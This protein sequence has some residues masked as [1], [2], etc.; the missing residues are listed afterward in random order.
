MIEQTPSGLN[1][2]LSDIPLEIMKQGS[3]I[4]FDPQGR[5]LYEVDGQCVSYDVE[6]DSY[7]KDLFTDKL[8]SHDVK[9]APLEA[10]MM[11]NRSSVV[12]LHQEMHFH[13]LGAVRIITEK[14]FSDKFNSPESVAKAREQALAEVNEHVLNVFAQAVNAAYDPSTQTIDTAFLNKVLDKARK[15]IS[16]KAMQAVVNGLAS[17]CNVTLNEEELASVNL[18]HIAEETTATTN[19]IIHTDV[20]NGLLTVIEGTD[21][22]AHN[23]QATISRDKKSIAT[24]QMKTYKLSESG[25][26]KESN[27]RLQIRTPSPVQKNTKKASFFNRLVG[28]TKTT[29]AFVDDV[30]AKFEEVNRFYNLNDS[31]KDP[32][33]GFPKAIIYA[34]YTAI[35]DTLDNL[36]GK[37]QQTE[38]AK[39]I[40]QGMHQYN[41]ESKLGVL[42]KRPM[43]FV[44]NISVN[45]YGERLSNNSRSGLVRESTLLAEMAML[46]T[47]SHVIENHKGSNDRAKSVFNE[48][49][50]FLQSNPRGEYFCDSKEGR[51]ALAEIKEIKRELIRMGFKEDF[52]PFDQEDIAQKAV[53]NMMAHDAHHKHRYAKTIQALTVFS[54]DTMGGCKSGNERAQAINGRVAILDALKGDNLSP[55]QKACKESLSKLSD[56]TD[57]DFKTN[58]KLF[59]Q[60]L[61]SLYNKNGLQSAASL[62]SCVDQ[63]ASAKVKSKLIFSVKNIVKWALSKFDRNYAEDSSLSN[64]SQNKAGKMQAHKG[65]SSSLKNAFCEMKTKNAGFS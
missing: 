6:L 62:V 60:Q 11:M 18:K 30:A 26:V 34:R 45:G 46:H 16:G 55:E 64:L 22:T 12:P 41:A 28:K 39:N 47:A 57:P 23:R 52:M 19:D 37:N 44:Q 61:N 8:K 21:I 4:L 14:A 42:Q 48:Y 65:F 32:A 3:P 63:F 27:N 53:L 24:R 54:T 59:N 31:L 35:N 10:Y 2:M 38:S 33:E 50:K 15:D 5:F 51:N 58:L 9:Q 49:E 40:I 1:R 7:L 56:P 13:V 29:K 20:K 43:V 36:Q 25:L 17:E